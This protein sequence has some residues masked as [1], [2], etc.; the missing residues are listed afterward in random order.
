MSW[1]DLKGKKITEVRPV[2]QNEVV[3]ELDGSKI[4][5]IRAKHPPDTPESEAQL[6]MEMKQA[7]T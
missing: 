6:T 7:K 3:L 5:K 1:Q 4:V 2:D